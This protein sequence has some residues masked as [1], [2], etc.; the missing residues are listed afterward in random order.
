[1]QDLYIGLMSG[2]SADGIDAALVDFSRPQPSIVATHYTAYSPDLREKILALCQP[3]ENEIGRLGT[4][5]TL[6]GKAFA[7]AVNCLLK[8]TSV[9]SQEVKAIG[10]HGQTIRHSPDKLNRFTLQIADPNTIAAETGITTVA[11]FR[12]KDIALGGQ[13]APLVPGFH[14][15]V[16]TS[17]SINRAIVNIG[18]IANVTF[19]MKNNP[20]PI[21]GFDL[22]PGNVLLDAWINHHLHKNHDLN[23]EWSNQGRVNT[24]LLNQLRKD[25]FF[26]LP[27][28]K[29][30]GR[31]HFNLAWLND[32][33]NQLGVEL[34]AVDVQA[35]LVELTARS[36]IEPILQYMASGEML[37]CGGGVHNAH[38]MSRLHEL[39]KPNLVVSSTQKYGLDPDWIEAMA[40]AWLAR[41]TLNKQIGNLP[42][43][44]GAK[45][46]AILGGIYYAL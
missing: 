46:A 9:Q 1:M 33:I 3:G 19:L 8:N 36:I 5:D 14:Q 6:L 24:P 35:T 42:S 37:I 20:A 11:D 28:P 16:L 39:A 27:P 26:S 45:Q 30:T 32:H 40:F 12:R 38:L 7:Q 13:G 4:L 18:G 10:S 31:E 34:T 2:T 22:G 41:Q 29:S 25:S 23:G 21:T 15:H 17:D 44:T 43:V